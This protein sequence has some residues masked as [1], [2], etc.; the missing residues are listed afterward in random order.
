MK[1][2]S[3]MKAIVITFFVY[4]LLSWVIPTGSYQNG[5]FTK[6]TTSPVGISDFLIYPISTSITSIFVLSA[7]VI[8][9]IGGLYGV[10]NKTG[11]YQNIVEGASE[12][13]K[14]SEKSFLVISILLF[15]VLA[16]LTTLILPLFILVPFFIAVILKLGFN[17]ITAFLSTVGAILVGCM[18]STVGYN[19][20]GYNF[21]NYFFNLKTTENLGFKILLLVLLVVVLLIYVLKTSSITAKKGKKTAEEVEIPL[22]KKEEKSK[23]SSTALIVISVISFVIIMVAMFNW[24]GALGK[25]KTIFDTWYTNLIE[26]KVNGYPLFANLLGSVKQFGYWTN[27]EL[28]MAIALVTLIIGFVYNL[29]FKDTYEA[30]VEGMKEILPVAV[31]S[32]FANILL[33]VVNSASATFVTTIYH[34][35]FTAV[36]GFNFMTM[37]VAG[38]IGSIG[39]SQFPYL[40]N[41]IYDPVNAL[42]AKS[43]PEA[44]FILQAIYGFTMLLVPTSVG[45]VIGLKYLGISYKEWLKENWRLLL[46][47]FAT[48]LIV[49]ILVT[50]I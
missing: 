45:L 2:N 12:K 31:V 6:G 48:A 24:S 49:I 47:L 28:A 32:V 34:S 19:V 16:S 44:A 9:L 27:Y 43:I 15:A 4:I 22:Y 23:K 1:K 20:E 30:A 37:T 39:Y 26:T 46:S 42:Y 7:L 21:V 35:F 18:G 13:F 36:K 5:V 11:V 17:K 25:E 10:M 50:L 8:L 38:L 40:M 41:S 29:K 14:G 3:I 33:L